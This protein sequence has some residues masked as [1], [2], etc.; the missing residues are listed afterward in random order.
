MA[1]VNKINGY[2]IGGDTFD[3]TVIPKFL[4]LLNNVTF[5]SGEHKVCSLSSYLPND[6][7]DYMVLF[8]GEYWAASAGSCWL[9]SGNITSGQSKNWYA[10]VCRTNHQNPTNGVRTLG[11]N[12]VWLPIFNKDRNVTWI[13]FDSNEKLYLAYLGVFAYRRIG[14]ND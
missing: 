2:T 13:N 3:S 14:K 11:G 6:G 12:A 5:A 7:Y 10:R 8:S 1:I 9:E 4:C